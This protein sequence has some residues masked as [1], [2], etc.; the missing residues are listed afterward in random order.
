MVP[1][2]GRLKDVFRFRTR[3][4]LKCGMIHISCRSKK[5][6]VVYII[7]IR[8][9]TNRNG[10]LQHIN[11]AW[12]TAQALTSMQPET[13]STMNYLAEYTSRVLTS[14]GMF[15]HDNDNV[16]IMCWSRKI[17]VCYSNMIPKFYFWSPANGP[18]SYH[19]SMTDTYRWWFHLNWPILVLFSGLMLCSVEPL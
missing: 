16:Q 3:W 5:I 14:T 1:R 2:V 18:R 8:T 13:C 9:I 15:I 12:L 4:S 6:K 7:S 17:N 10:E 19:W 11:S